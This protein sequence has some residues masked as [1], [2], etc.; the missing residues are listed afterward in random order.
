MHLPSTRKAYYADE[1][2]FF[3]KTSIGNVPITASADKRR[4]RVSRADPVVLPSLKGLSQED[5]TPPSHCY[6][7]RVSRQLSRTGA[8]CSSVLHECF[9]KQ[10]EEV[11]RSRGQF[12]PTR[13]ARTRQ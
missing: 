2:T 6:T 7:P 11:L 13:D 12:H 9:P 5:V 3:R 8:N 10:F 1:S 4:T